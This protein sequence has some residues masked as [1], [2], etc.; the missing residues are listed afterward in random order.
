[1]NLTNPW[2]RILTLATASGFSLFDG[3]A[4]KMGKQPRE[5]I[6]HIYSARSPEFRHAAG[7]LLA[8]LCSGQQHHDFG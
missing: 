3:C 1:M 4:L 5:E 2:A 7:S 6:A 8:K